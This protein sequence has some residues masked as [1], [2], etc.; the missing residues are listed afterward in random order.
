MNLK[1]LAN[2]YTGSGKSF[3]CLT[4]PKLYWITNEP[5]GSIL[6][7][8][9]PEL[10]KNVVKVVEALPSPAENMK[11]YFERLD[12]AIVEAHEM[13]KK[14]EVSSLGFDNMTYHS[15]NRW[16]YI[17]AHEKIVSR[18][19]D[20]DTRSMYGAL[21]RYLYRFTLISLLS[22]P[23]NVCVTAHEQMEG[24]EAME[25]KTDKST[26]IVPN[27]LGGFREKIGGMF[28]ASIYLDKKKVG[29]DYKYYARCQKG[30]M[31]EAKNRYGLPEIIEN[32]S[33]QSII[34]NIKK[35]G[36]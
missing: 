27:L 11:Q 33:Y 9:H 19:G 14:G 12:K 23:G 3:F 35:E 2:G 36:K 29:N 13:A 8:T 4:H 10:K 28:S 25:R 34:N 7:E 15:E 18:N 22:F 16:L 6:L 32:V 1:T 17:Q 26:P 30:A 24:E 5:G 20:V 21:S 31:R